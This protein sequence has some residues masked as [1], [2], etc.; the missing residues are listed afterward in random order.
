MRRCLTFLSKS[1]NANRVLSS[2]KNTT[3]AKVTSP[4]INAV[5]ILRHQDDVLIRITP[6]FSPPVS[7]RPV[8][9]TCVIDT[10]ASMADPA[11][12]QWCGSSSNAGGGG[13]KEAHGLTVLDIV[14]HAVKAVGR[15]L[16]P[17]DRLGVVAFSTD[18]Y[19]VMPLT[20][21]DNNGRELLDKQLKH[22]YAD[23]MTNL[24]QGQ[25]LAMEQV[26]LMTTTTA[27][28][29]NAILMLTDGCPNLNPPR[30]YIDTLRSYYTESHHQLP[31]F[32]VHT[33]GFGY[34]LDSELLYRI[35]QESNGMY[36]FIP[37]ADMV[38][39]VFVNTVSGI[40]STVESNI[41]LTVSTNKKPNSWTDLLQ[42]DGVGNLVG[43]LG[44]ILYGQPRTIHLNVPKGPNGKRD[45]KVE[46]VFSSS[47]ALRFENVESCT[48]HE[49]K[50]YRARSLYLES[51]HKIC[52]GCIV[53]PE[54]LTTTTTSASFTT[55]EPKEGGLTSALLGDL[56]GEVAVSLQE[57]HTTWRKHYA[58][59]LI[60]ANLLEQCTNF[61]DKSVAYYS[62][63]NTFF[64][65]IQKQGE[66]VFL[67]LPPPK[68]TGKAILEETNNPDKNASDM[69][70]YYNAHGGCVAG[71]SNVLMW[72]N[73]T[74]PIRDL[75]PGMVVHGG[76]KVMHAVR[77]WFSTSPPHLCSLSEGK[78]LISPY[79]PV[80][81]HSSVPV[82]NWMFPCNILP[83]QK[84]VSEDNALYCV[85]LD[86][87]HYLVIEGYDIVTWGHTFTSCEVVSHPYFGSRDVVVN[88]LNKIGEVEGVVNLS[89]EM[90]RRGSDGR[91]CGILM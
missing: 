37:S 43:N 19:I 68:P 77:I 82:S 74:S 55:P 78:L 13:K 9:L 38:G 51:L 8:N 86:Q 47:P 32:G 46:A 53:S 73:T 39:S 59:S 24:W 64:Q 14:T 50:P 16:G 63:D 4:W 44:P 49:V 79:H 84:S 71:G 69:F 22:V 61:K 10:S 60:R 5:K 72:D 11:T 83:C 45:V 33:F 75:R 76:F 29:H 21:M 34:N 18:A 56:H 42:P 48:L 52:S 91:I 57:K 41:N 81:K 40:L 80:R 30:G 90:M 88:D 20:P 2:V 6:P 89:S 27:E 36:V 12:T 15:M 62:R 3:S 70:A 23:G 66:S 17:Q 58:R 67:T 1:K 31:S 85:V 35:A 28:S 65:S 7:R 26:K 87:G 25:A 54:G